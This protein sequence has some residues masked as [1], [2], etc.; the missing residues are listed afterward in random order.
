[1]LK[2]SWTKRMR[3]FAMWILAIAVGMGAVTGVL[4]NGG[5]VTPKEEAE[6]VM[7]AGISFAQ[8]ML[9]AHGEFYPFGFAMTA[10]GKVAA[11]AADAPDEH[12]PSRELIDNLMAG[13]RSG[14]ARGHYKV[15][16]VFFDVRVQ[17]PGTSEKTDAVQVGLEHVSGYCVDV[18]FPYSRTVEGEVNYEA[19]FASKRAGVVFGTC[20]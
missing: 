11:V 3:H 7:S 9:A 8:K 13:F 14:A 10:D 5:A 12:R 17:Q 16:A 2:V 1:M 18:F 4:P 19:V 6:Q 15:T 20:K